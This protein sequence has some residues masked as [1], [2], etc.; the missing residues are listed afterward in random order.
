VEE[1]L[2]LPEESPRL[3]KLLA[4]S[5]HLRFRVAYVP[6][7]ARREEIVERIAADFEHLPLPQATA[8]TE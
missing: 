4:S 1:M 5:G 7:A 2:A 6:D 8:L 3:A